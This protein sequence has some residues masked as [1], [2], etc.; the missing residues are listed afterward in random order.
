MHYRRLGIIALEHIPGTGDGS[1]TR[2]LRILSPLCMPFHHSG[3]LKRE[4]PSESPLHNMICKPRDLEHPEQASN[5]QSYDKCKRAHGKSRS[6]DHSTD[7]S[8]LSA[9]V[10]NFFFFH[11]SSPFNK[12]LRNGSLY[13]FLLY[14]TNMLK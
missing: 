12:L 10:S 6:D 14:L 1:R 13:E 9:K 2:S 3:K 5:G 8:H 11:N 7:L 4:N